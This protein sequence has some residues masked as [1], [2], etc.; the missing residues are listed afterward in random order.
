M[1]L[2]DIAADT[3]VWSIV[4]ITTDPELVKEIQSRLQAHSF[5]V[6]TV[7]GVWGNKT[8]AAL[9]KFCQI[10][11][12]STEEISPQTAKLLLTVEKPVE[13]VE[14]AKVPSSTSSAPTPA[15]SQPSEPQLK[16]STQSSALGPAAQQ[17]A[18]AMT[19]ASALKFVLR[20]EG[21]FSDHP[22]D[23]G[24]ATMKG[25][26]QRIYD[27]YRLSKGLTPCFVWEITDAEVRELY[28][29]RY[30]KPCQAELMIPPLATVHFDT[31]V[32]FGVRGAVAFLQEVLELRMDGD[33]GP[34]TKA[35]LMKNNT[36]ELAQR[37]CQ[38]RINYRHERVRRAPSQE[39]FLRGWLNRDNDLMKWI[40]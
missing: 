20:W 3:I 29:T 15:V 21:S 25:V 26:T 39:V 35:T 5:T 40:A 22:A 24:R 7:D 12:L 19:F 37:Y 9:V 8:A 31:A 32:N 1:N 13:K 2:K 23:S 4:S 33:F 6:G 36:K 18:D 34:L 11:H 28:Y 14:A 38:A 17:T 16:P 10:N 30:W 27:S